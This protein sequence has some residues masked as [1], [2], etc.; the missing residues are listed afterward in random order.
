MADLKLIL[1]S[2]DG[3]VS[4]GESIFPDEMLSE[5]IIAELV[6]Q[7]GLPSVDNDNRRIEY[8]LRLDNK[9]V[10]LQKGKSLR[11]QQ[12][13]DQDTLRLVSSNPI[14][15]VTPKPIIEPPR[16]DTVEVMLY[17]PD[18]QEPAKPVKFRLDM[19][20]GEAIRE[21][22]RNHNLPARDPENKRLI[23]YR[24]SS[25]AHNRE[26]LNEETFRSARIQ[27]M[28]RLSLVREAVAG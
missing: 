20:V 22:L 23:D 14:P 8:R 2:P 11:E 17:L 16:G 19:T 18:V 27:N 25:K 1:R 5:D 6:E 3:K 28:D 4:W 7:L 12:V 9:G 24:L 21:I 13:V 15:T 10:E 26:L